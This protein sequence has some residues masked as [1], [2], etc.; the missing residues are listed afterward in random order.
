LINEKIEKIGTP[1]KDWKGIGFYAGVKTA[2]N[3]A[4]IIN[5]DTRDAL[6]KREEKSSEILKRVLRGRNIKRFQY[7]FENLYLIN[8]YNGENNPVKGKP[9]INR[10]DVVNDYK[11]VFEFMTNFKEQLISRED[12]GEHWT[13]LRNCAFES[14]WLKDKIVWMEI[15]DRGNYTFDDKG[16][17]LT[18]SAYFLTGHSLKYLLA[19]LN[20]KVCDFYFFQKTAIIA[21]GRKRYTKQYVEQNPIPVISEA[22]QK[23]FIDLVDKI[24]AIKNENPEIDTKDLE[25]EIDQLVYKLYELTD[26]EIK[27]VEES[28]NH[29]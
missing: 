11:E 27:I 2:C 14:E 13:N 24:L 26:A 22:D 20:S 12:K 3:D 23:P 25:N 21:G 17:Y 16:M 18:N 10:I 5:K 9:R 29:A 15:S 19:V 7:E 8:T 4:F 1:L 28:F 6:I